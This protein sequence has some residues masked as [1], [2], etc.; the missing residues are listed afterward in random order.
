MQCA[1]KYDL[2]ALVIAAEKRASHELCQCFCSVPSK[3][4]APCGL[5]I[6][7]KTKSRNSKLKFN[8]VIM[9]T[10][11]HG[12]QDSEHNRYGSFLQ[13]RA[14]VSLLWRYVVFLYYARAGSSD[15]FSHTWEVGPSF[16]AS[17]DL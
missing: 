13:C 6:V 15:T 16:Q 11:L 5:M 1:F 7:N 10:A 2:C 4:T 8:S 9:M 12:T 14:A 17:R 3:P